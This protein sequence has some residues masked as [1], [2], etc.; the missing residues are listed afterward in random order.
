MCARPEGDLEQDFG[1][2]EERRANP[3]P[4]SNALG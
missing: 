3:V 1:K 2:Y 4:R